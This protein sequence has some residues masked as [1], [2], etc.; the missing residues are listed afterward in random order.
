MTQMKPKRHRAMHQVTGA[1]A[2]AAI[3]LMWGAGVL[4]AQEIPPGN[5]P[6]AQSAPATDVSTPAAPSAAPS[7]A[8]S[9]APSEAPSAAPNEA[10]S[11]ATSEAPSAP[12]SAPPTTGQ[13]GTASTQPSANG[14]IT[15]GVSADGKIRLMVNQTQVITTSQPV[16]PVSVGNPD[17]ADVN[18]LGPN[19][20]LITAKKQ[21]STQ[22]IVWDDSKRSQVA[23]IIIGMNLSELQ[24]E[25]NAAFPGQKITATSL[26]GAVALRGQVSDIRA[27][28]QAVSIAQP[29][30]PKVLDLLEIA[31]GQQVSLQVRFAEVSRSATNQLGVN[32]AMS[33]GIFS[34]GSNI[35]QV[36]PSTFVDNGV[37]TPGS[38]GTTTGTGVTLFGSGQAGAVAFRYFLQ[39]LRQNSLL[40]V[41]AEPNLVAIS[42][43]EASFLAGGEF[44]IPV[45]QTGTGGGS[46]I[47][48]DYKE[49]GV[50][51]TFTPIVLG[52]GR[53]RLKLTPEVS[54]L[55]FSS[56]LVIQGSRIPIINKRT[57]STTIELEDGQSFAI[58]G[59]LDHS[60]AASKDVTPLLGDI[61]VLGA[62]FRSVSYNRKETELVV[63]VTPRLVEPMNPGQIP[64]LPG[65]TWRHP[66]EGDLFLNQDLGGDEPV[67]ETATTSGS[68]SA[69]NDNPPPLYFG[70]RGFTP[71]A[72]AAASTVSN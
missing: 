14:L 6:A 19:T 67:S 59:L 15:K 38:V 66:S 10:P 23:D 53:I 71:P 64:K 47:T 22:L 72:Q 60:V 7:E 37:A 28:E 29:Y 51:L 33:D 70:Q 16:N 30:S 34:A 65:E 55:D 58:A 4:P 20:L 45:P 41:L 12:Q 24:N 63:L 44:P 69:R 39:A 1:I 18:V 56:P 25:L 68:A 5:A 50:R 62:L 8:P 32:F 27:A 9:A 46:T 42:G 49:F 3:T 52:D 13:P 40:R 43:Q 54:D 31:G 26:N 35:G 21:G 17:I 57:V 2:A 11:P 48:I 61:P 36:S